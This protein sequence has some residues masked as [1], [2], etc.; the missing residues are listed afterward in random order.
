MAIPEV[1]SVAS[2][3]AECSSCFTSGREQL[4]VFN[5]L[6]HAPERYNIAVSLLNVVMRSGV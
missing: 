5:F 4:Y 6:A 2:E 1:L 3:T